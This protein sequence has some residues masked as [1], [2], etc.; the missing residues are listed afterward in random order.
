MSE[1]NSG[2]HPKGPRILIKPLEIPMATESGIILATDSQ[3]EREQMA[4]TTGEV[5]EVGPEAFTDCCT[6]WC[7]AGDRV[8]FAK[9]AGLLYLGKDGNNYRIINDDNIIAT[10]DGDVK[11]VD[12]YLKK[13]TE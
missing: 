13:G 6:V 5:V 12:P 3:K 10:L 9:Y 1:N 8:V 7:K 4:N 11:L 2:I